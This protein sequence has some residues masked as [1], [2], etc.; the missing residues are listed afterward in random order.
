MID[1]EQFA[2]GLEGQ[3]W[4]VEELRTRGF[5]CV[6]MYENCGLASN[7][8]PRLLEPLDRDRGP[9]LADIYA[10]KAG[11]HWWF[12]VKR[13]RAPSCFQGRV[14]YGIKEYQANSYMELETIEKISVWIIYID[15]K[16]D[17]WLR[18]RMGELMQHPLRRIRAFDDGNTFY[19]P[20]EAFT[21]FATG[22][23]ANYMNRK[24]SLSTVQSIPLIPARDPFT[25]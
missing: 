7:H 3:Q 24:K 14:E 19:W 15:D 12:E 16:H 22:L 11:E 18:A 21:L 2:Y 9:L 17:R 10:T 5:Y 20:F 1:P 13:T 4:V 8:A 23:N 6:P 25:F